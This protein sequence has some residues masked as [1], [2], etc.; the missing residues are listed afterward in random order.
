MCG[1]VLPSVAGLAATVF[2][3]L[4]MCCCTICIYYIHFMW[5]YPWHA[6]VRGYYPLVPSI[7]AIRTPCSS[8]R[9]IRSYLN[10]YMT[11]FGARNYEWLS[12]AM[13]T[14]HRCIHYRRLR[15]LYSLYVAISSICPCAAMLPI[16]RQICY[17][18]QYKHMCLLHVQYSL[19]EALLICVHT[20]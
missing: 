4:A 12:V 18:I 3:Q 16:C 13:F 11:I 7:F 8:I 20:C 1:V 10:R 6:M 9:Y 19:C 17:I 15:Y 5:I 2:A 14:E